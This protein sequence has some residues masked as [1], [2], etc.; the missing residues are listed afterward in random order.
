MNGWKGEVISLVSD[1]DLD[2]INFLCCGGMGNSKGVTPSLSLCNLVNTPVSHN[3]K[4]TLSSEAS[5]L[6]GFLAKMDICSNFCIK[7][8]TSGDLGVWSEGGAFLT[9][10]GYEGDV[11]TTSDLWSEDF[12]WD[13]EGVEVVDG[14]WLLWIFFYWSL[15]LYAIHIHMTILLESK[16]WS[17]E[18]LLLQHG[19]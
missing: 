14:F 12:E 15:G 7:Q 8:R 19:G 2:V 16:C 10:L 6:F 9:T 17:L 11:S 13:L 5:D 1:S 18:F 4:V 3:K